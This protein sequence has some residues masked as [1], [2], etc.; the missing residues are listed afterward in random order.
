VLRPED[1]RSLCY[2][3]RYGR[4]K[5]SF[6]QQQLIDGKRVFAATGWEVPSPDEAVMLEA[7]EPARNVWLSDC[8]RFCPICLEGAYHSYWFQFEPLLCCPVHAV[9]LTTLC[10]RCFRVVGSYRVGRDLFATPLRCI[11][12]RAFLAGAPMTLASHTE[13]RE[14]S[15]Q[16][17]SAF[18][19]L[20]QW[21][22]DSGKSLKSLHMFARQ[23]RD[24]L[25]RRPLSRP[26]LLGLANELCALPAG[27]TCSR[28]CPVLA[29]RWRLNLVPRQRASYQ[30][31]SRW[32]ERATIP[33]T[34]YRTVLRRL[35]RWLTTAF[36][37]RF[38]P[39]SYK[40]TSEAEVRMLPTP[41]AAY[42]LLR[43][44]V[45][46]E[47]YSIYARVHDA[48]IR[49]A[50]LP[51]VHDGR[52]PPRLICAAQYV[53]MYVDCVCHIQRERAA[54]GSLEP[55][56]TLQDG[57]ELFVVHGRTETALIGAV[58]VPDVLALPVAVTGRTCKAA[59]LLREL[60]QPRF[61]KEG[62]E[63]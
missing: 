59:E 13:F 38:W 62:S 19:Y 11:R 50:P 16:L 63:I 5:D 36:L 54:G 20:D 44:R 42:C 61:A 49:D 24:L 21:T 2:G 43:R 17:S 32:S 35:R 60:T 41:L 39:S 45:E 48:W 18:H 1:I 29:I 55:P 53:G 14:H 30:Y 58:I 15:D 3:H 47:W 6:L 31:R 4:R 52:E 26:L 40:Y 10:P 8:F 56:F 46:G 37:S 51:L 23:N 33:L 25:L 22:K 28:G 57:L 27:C 34:V 12:C 7:L 9:P